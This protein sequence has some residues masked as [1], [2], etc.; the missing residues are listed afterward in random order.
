MAALCK[1][2]TLALYH[3]NNSSSSSSRQCTGFLQLPAT[4]LSGET[5]R[6]HKTIGNGHVQVVSCTLQTCAV[7]DDV[8]LE[9]QVLGRGPT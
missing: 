6:G 3:T 7:H 1:R 9:P 2:T 5:E 4:A 8:L